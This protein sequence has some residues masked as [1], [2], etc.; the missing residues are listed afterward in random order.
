MKIIVVITIFCCF[1]SKLYSQTVQLHFPRFAGKEWLFTVSVGNATDSLT[2]GNL[3]ENGRACFVLPEHYRRLP[4]VI[5]QWRL[6]D[7]GGLDMILVPTENFA[8]SCLSENPSTDNIQYSGSP[9]N[10]FLQEYFDLR[11]DV[12]SKVEALVAAI[13]AYADNPELLLVLETEWQRQKQA[14][15]ALQQ[16]TMLQPFY[17][18]RF[19]RIVNVSQGLPPVLAQNK[20]EADRL[21]CHYIR[22]EVDM[23]VLY[24]SGHWANV[25]R[26]W[27]NPYI[28]N[29]AYTA[30]LFSDYKALLGRIKDMEVASIFKNTVEGILTLRKRNDLVYSL[31]HEGKALE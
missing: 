7:G 16:K 11:Q 14:Y 3:D 9:E 31:V 8:V 1:L 30:A 29:E 19:A 5:A 12:L 23:E 4:G 24:A 18:A 10:A 21:I 25:I 6:V 17:A 28:E 13:R 27:L 20:Q 2:G 26:R 22:D 15:D